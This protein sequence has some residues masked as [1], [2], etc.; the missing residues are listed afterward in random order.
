MA[1]V[2]TE[3]R[4]G[5]LSTQQHPPGGAGRGGPGRTRGESVDRS[6]YSIAGGS[7]CPRRPT[8]P[9][10][11]PPPRPTR[12]CGSGSG[13][14]SGSGGGG[15]SG[16]GGGSGGGRAPRTAHRAKSRPVRLLAHGGAHRGWVCS[17]NMPTGLQ[18]PRVAGAPGPAWCGKPR[19]ASS[20]A[21]RDGGPLVVCGAGSRRVRLLARRGFAVRVS[22]TREGAAQNMSTGL[23]RTAARPG[24][25]RVSGGEVGRR[26]HWRHWRRRLSVWWESLG[27]SAG[28]TSRAAA[29]GGGRA[30]CV[31]PNMSTG[32]Q[33]HDGSGGGAQAGRPVA[34]RAKSRRVRLPAR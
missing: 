5:R 9:Q 14:G 29:C 24:L 19:L 1:G 7:C 20:P 16:S 22:R 33:I 6:T 30:G 13:S 28:P 3:S 11:P 34:H 17:R 31:R 2:R 27:K 21:R 25:S 23:H 18:I 10:S 15:G 32:L 12:S 26:R 8:S 4:R